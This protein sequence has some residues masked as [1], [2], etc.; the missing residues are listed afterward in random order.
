[1]GSGEATSAAAPCLHIIRLVARGRSRSHR[2]AMKRTRLALVL[3]LASA[4]PT[5]RLPA[6]CPDGSPPPCG[7]P[8][9]RPA[10]PAANSVAVLYFEARDTADAYLDGLTEDLTSLLGSVARVQVKS[11]GVVR[12]AQRAAPDNAPAIARALGVRYLVDGNVRRVGTRIRVSTR[13]VNGA[14]AV[15]AWGDVFDRT[16][17]ELLALPSLIARE[18][19]LHVGGPAPSSEAGVLGTLRTRSPAAYDHYLRGNFFLALRSPEGT[20]RAVAEYREAE[21]LDSGFAAAIGRAAYAHA[22]ARANTY[23]LPDVPIESLAVRGLGL[24][25]R[26]LRR[27]STSSDAWMARGFLLAFARPRTTESSLEAFQRSIALD[28]KNAEAHHQYGAILVWLGRDEEANREQHLAL[29]LDPGPAVTF[30]DLAAA[31]D[32]RDT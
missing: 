20:A 27:D 23:R 8:A 31:P 24:A 4:T 7:R 16:P 30:L 26:A 1:M 14:T 2:R 25:D 29:A 9:A 13:L 10:P 15:A 18:V 19:A 17:D 22:I 12:R 5:A 28:P 3:G 21:R 6:Q 32:A 11:P